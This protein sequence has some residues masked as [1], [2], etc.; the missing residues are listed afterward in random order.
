MVGAIGEMGAIVVNSGK[1][2][3]GCELKVEFAPGKPF[4][5]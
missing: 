1:S 3:G 4:A 2:A 5:L